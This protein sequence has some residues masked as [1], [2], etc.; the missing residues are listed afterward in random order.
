MRS[1]PQRVWA[2]RSFPDGAKESTLL[3]PSEVILR[4]AAALGEAQPAAV[5][6][7]ADSKSWL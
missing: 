2:E 5:A 6:S 1:A 4:P 7:T 3:S